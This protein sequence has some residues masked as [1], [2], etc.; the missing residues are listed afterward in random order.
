MLN[1]AQSSI[2]KAL[3][4]LIILCIISYL[5]IK[6]AIA[7]LMAA[8]V[9]KALLFFRSLKEIDLNFTLDNEDW[10]RFTNNCGINTKIYGEYNHFSLC[11]L[12]LNPDYPANTHVL[13]T[14][15]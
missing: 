6:L 7:F 9:L 2:M 12:A 11:F 13:Q 10:R 8:I 4:L 15:R 14:L 3:A 1:I 5:N